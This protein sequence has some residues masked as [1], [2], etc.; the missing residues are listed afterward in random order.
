[1]GGYLEK[2]ERGSWAFHFF[3][4]AKGLLLSMGV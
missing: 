4:C 1:M 3:S 2:G